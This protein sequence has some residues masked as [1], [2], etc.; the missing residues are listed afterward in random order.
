MLALGRNWVKCMLKLAVLFAQISLKS[1]KYLWF[2]KIILRCI[3]PIFYGLLQ[4][5]HFVIGQ[6]TLWF[7]ICLISLILCVF[8]CVCAGTCGGQ[9]T[10]S[11][12]NVWLPPSLRQIVLLFQFIWQASPCA[13]RISLVSSSSVALVALG[14]QTL[15]PQH[16]VLC[17]FWEFKL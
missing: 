14:F 9:T 12:L 6:Y 1:L 10:I 2:N 5:V 16:L 4:I 15:L 3:S 8:A 13:S 7:L 11:G 17:G